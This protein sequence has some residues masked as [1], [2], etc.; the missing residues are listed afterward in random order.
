MCSPEEPPGVEGAERSEGERRE[1]GRPSPARRL[2][3]PSER[4]ALS[5]VMSREGGWRAGR[6]SEATVVPLESAGQQNRGRGK[7]RCFVHAS[8]AGKGW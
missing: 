5:P 2:R 4:R 1:L 8:R 7:D 6:A 3:K